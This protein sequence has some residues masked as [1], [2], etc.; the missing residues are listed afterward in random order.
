[1]NAALRLLPVAALGGALAVFAA[2]GCAT[3]RPESAGRATGSS[4]STRSVSYTLHPGQP[5][6]ITVRTLDGQLESHLPLALVVDGTPREVSVDKSQLRTEA[7]TVIAPAHFE[8]DGA[9]VVVTLSMRADPRGDALTL[10]AEGPSS[11][12][13]HTLALGLEVSSEGGTPPAVFVSGVG[14][15]AD[16]G[17]VSGRFAVFSEATPSSPGQVAS[18]VLGM[19]SGTGSLDVTSASDEEQEP[20]S[21]MRILVTGPKAKLGAPAAL[22]DL[23]IVLAPSTQRVWGPL[24]QLTGEVVTRVKGLVKGTGDHSKVY[25]LDGD[26]A[27]RIVADANPDGRFDVEVPKSVV[28]WYAAIDA[29]RTSTPVLFTP[30]T[31]WELRLDVSPGGELRVRIVDPDT[32]KPITARLLLHGIDGTLDPSFGPDYRASGAGPLMD[33]LRGEVTTP[34][35]AGRYRVAA[36][37]G[38]EWSVDATNVEI[39]PGR[40]TAVELAP[41]HVVPTPAVVSADLHVHARPSFD[42]P[43]SPEDRVLSLV[44]AGIDFAVPTEHNIV[45]DYS[46]ML[47]TL[48]LGHELASVPG[49]E[50]TTYNPRFGHF[51]VFPYRGTVPPYRATTPTALFQAARRGDATRVLQVNHPRLPMAIGYFNVYHY[52]P[53]SGKPPPPGMRM[54][55]D[56]LEV[57]NGYDMAKNDRVEAVM[58][59]WFALLD[60]GY[61]FVATGDSDSHRIQYQWAGYP[62]TLIATGEAASGE[63]APPDTSA[64]VAA[65]KK[66]HATVTNGPVVELEVGGGHPGDEIVSRDDP[67]PIHLVVRAAPWIDVTSVEI[68]AGSRSL[69]TFPV[70]SRPTKLGPEPGS[71]EEAAER[72]VRFEREWS[73]PVGAGNTWVVAIARGTRKLDDV[74]PFMPTVPLAFTNPIWVTRDPKALPSKRQKAP[75]VHAK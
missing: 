8:L 14:P 50:V 38:I 65:L 49:V 42:T 21:P 45:G 43:V 17:T 23:K 73:V 19:T 40:Q 33:A 72:T 46:P 64:I 13:D 32:Q 56:T 58:R 57:F 68:V 41:R 34:L 36:T 48:D 16:L 4:I 69:A 54:D 52:Q 25:G 59:D 37:K 22:V 60:Q 28:E 7:D 70:P 1:M 39:Q 6:T 29:T 75:G 30:G 20:G 44:A 74:L 31:P 24:Y 67:V 51:G 27:P 53:Q 15:V 62:R 18:E 10:S 66:G 3:P 26:G 11:G 47:A 12:S 63:K 71:L 35:P 9:D 2:R 61:R 5:P 55:F